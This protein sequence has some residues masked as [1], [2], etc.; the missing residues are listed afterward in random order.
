[1]HSTF[2]D[3]LNFLY[4]RSDPSTLSNAEEQPPLPLPSGSEEGEIYRCQIDFCD[5]E[6][7]NDQV[8]PP[9][10]STI[11]SAK[12]HF[13]DHD[14][15]HHSK[16][17]HGRE[18]RVA[19]SETDVLDRRAP[20]AQ[21]LKIED[22]HRRRREEEQ[23]R[24]MKR[25]YDE[26]M[27]WMMEEL[28][29]RDMTIDRLEQESRQYRTILG[30]NLQK[31]NEQ[32]KRQDEL[33]NLLDV[34]T[35][36]LQGAQAF[37][38]TADKIAGADVMRL[39]K[40]L[41][42]EVFQ[43]AA[44]ISVFEEERFESVEGRDEFD[45]CAVRDMED[46]LGEPILRYL[47]SNKGSD[48]HE[49]AAQ[50]ALQTL[51]LH[52]CVMII[53]S[54][55]W[56]SKVDRTLKDMYAKLQRKETQAISGR[57]RALT[58]A[59]SR[60]DLSTGGADVDTAIARVTDFIVLFQEVCVAPSK[61][62]AKITSSQRTW[63]V[64]KVSFILESASEINQAICESI[65]STDYEVFGPQSGDIIDDEEMEHHD[66]GG[67]GARD[68]RSRLFCTTGLGLRESVIKDGNGSVQRHMHAHVLMK[69]RVLPESELRKF[70][71]K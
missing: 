24:E 22:G 13:Q 67:F 20:P 1:M 35:R 5:C 44:Q 27:G 61:S 6:Q 37:L 54:W 51:L 9:E 7:V 38:G 57:W 29:K 62:G 23:L 53:S 36:E 63:I 21:G 42:N 48:D 16:T 33:R 71:R 31:M 39:V 17:R 4:R 10:S 68:K 59:M 69:A 25:G 49:L 45:E 56:K 70:N 15:G 64:E 28:Q 52:F 8:S 12:T 47:Q 34:R 19:K 26:K 30:E 50:C 65:T 58:Y 18:L 11:E 3:S 60:T 2:L 55:S 43:F 40:A 32:E 46:I 14:V 41:N 66:E